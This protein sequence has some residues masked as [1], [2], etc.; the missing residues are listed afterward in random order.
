MTLSDTV[1]RNL[2]KVFPEVSWRMMKIHMECLS[3]YFKRNS[4]ISWH[5]NF[6]NNEMESQYNKTIRQFHIILS[7]ITAKVKM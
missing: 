7:Q 4:A 6:V 3:N 2:K 1:T 5:K